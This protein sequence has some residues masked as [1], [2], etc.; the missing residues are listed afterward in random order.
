MNEL[1]DNFIQFRKYICPKTNYLT[2]GDAAST[3]LSFRN[4]NDVRRN[5]FVH[6]TLESIFQSQE[7]DREKLFP[8]ISDLTNELDQ[9]VIILFT[10]DFPDSSV[11]EDILPL[12]KSKKTKLV[13]E[14]QHVTKIE[15]TNAAFLNYPQKV[16]YNSIYQWNDKEEIYQVE[17]YFPALQIILKFFY[18]QKVYQIPQKVML[19]TSYLQSIPIGY[20]KQPAVSSRQQFRFLWNL[21]PHTVVPQ[22][23]PF[24]DSIENIRESKLRVLQRLSEHECCA[25]DGRKFYLTANDWDSL[26]SKA[27]V[28][29]AADDWDIY[30]LIREKAL[31]TTLNEDINPLHLLLS[32]SSSALSSSSA[33]AGNQQAHGGSEERADF[34]VDRI[35]ESLPEPIQK[36]PKQF[37]HSL[38]DYGCAEGGITAMLGQKLQLSNNSIYGADVR[39]ITQNTGFQFVQ[40]K[41]EIKNK[42]FPIGSILSNLSNQSISLINASMVFHHIIHIDHV[43]LELRRIIAQLPIN[44]PLASMLIIREHDC[45]NPSTGCFL[46]IVHGLY[47]L[48]WQSPVEWPSFIEEY[49]AFYR[50]REEWTTL[51][52]KYGWMLRKEQ[53]KAFDAATWSNWN[54][55]RSRFPNVARA[56]YAIYSPVPSFDIQYFIRTENYLLIP[57]SNHIPI[58]IHNEEDDDDNNSRKLKKRSREEADNPEGEDD[59]EKEPTFDDF[60]VYESKK[61]PGFHYKFFKYQNKSIWIEGNPEEMKTISI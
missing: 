50:N 4:D 6:E 25:R 19:T 46:D 16:K 12:L 56:Y 20:N 30:S 10:N 55:K 47:S 2:G 9:H 48:S 33:A 24:K 43:L 28:E 17:K 51:L 44:N 41:N 18:Y 31:G 34:L 57:N 42:P 1:I 5:H 15:E 14:I 60:D 40:L 11:K 7:F 22:S 37:F 35:I 32:P 26:I 8:S 23:L 27:L 54:A 38:L 45:P 53:P 49:E 61:Y 52:Q 21:W 13:A 29:R 58:H 59:D 39:K 3:L 36:N